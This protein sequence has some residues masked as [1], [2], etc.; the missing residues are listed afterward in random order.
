MGV[1][2]VHSAV[3]RLRVWFRMDLHKIASFRHTM[4]LCTGTHLRYHLYIEVKPSCKKYTFK[5]VINY[6]HM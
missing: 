2:K 4:I 6:Q 1:C 5:D 3:S